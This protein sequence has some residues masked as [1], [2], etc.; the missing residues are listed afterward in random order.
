MGT[1]NNAAR[2]NYYTKFD[3]WMSLKH[4]YHTELINPRVFLDTICD[5]IITLSEPERGSNNIY[6]FQSLS[7]KPSNLQD[8]P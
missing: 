1:V 8:S 3:L 6:Y 2:S 5:S 7:F 4:N